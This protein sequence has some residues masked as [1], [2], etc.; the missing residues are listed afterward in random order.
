MNEAYNILSQ[1]ITQLR[2]I[3]GTAGKYN[4]NIPDSSIKT[5]FQA[6]DEAGIY[7]SIWISFS[8]GGESFQ[9]DQ[10]TYDVPLVFEIYGYV[11]NETD[12]LGAALKLQSDI[13]TA[14]YEDWTLGS[15]VFE[16]DLSFDAGAYEVYGIVIIKMSVKYIKTI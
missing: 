4:N 3:D 9:G 5:D 2:A 11:T 6:V 13:Y 16:M 14:I 8:T 1:L 15:R 7:P 10:G 12:P